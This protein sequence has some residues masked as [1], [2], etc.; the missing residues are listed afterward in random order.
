MAAG[1][2]GGWASHGLLRKEAGWEE[3]VREEEE[4]AGRQVGDSGI[5]ELK[6]RKK[7]GHREPA[8]TGLRVLSGKN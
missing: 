6:A 4:A 7:E 8:R 5:S 3:L 1:S 2:E